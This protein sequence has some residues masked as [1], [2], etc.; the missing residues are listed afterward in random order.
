MSSAL[1]SL[2]KVDKGCY[3]PGYSQEVR[4]EGPVHSRGRPII[5]D[6]KRTRVCLA[7]ARKPLNLDGAR[8][9]NRTG[10]PLRAGDFKSQRKI[11]QAALSNSFSGSQSPLFDCHAAQCFRILFRNCGP[12]KPPI[13]NV[14]V[15]TLPEPIYTA[16]MPITHTSPPPAGA[17]R[18]RGGRVI[19]RSD[20]LAEALRH[21][22]VPANR[23]CGPPAAT[24]AA[25]PPRLR[26]GNGAAAKA[27]DRRDRSRVRPSSI[28]MAGAS[29][30]VVMGRPRSR[31]C[32]TL[33][34]AAPHRPW[35]H[36]RRRNAHRPAAGCHAPQ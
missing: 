6:Q 10:T 13:S 20:H 16:G 19:R 1:E 26:G 28:S 12:E 33:P 3:R 9:R 21:W 35:P 8:S 25:R 4:T 27:D 34:L 22:S 29:L 23:L 30:R 32:R 31:P 14:K 36:P 7:F 24:A 5:A 2:I 15:R 18:D 11:N 17:K